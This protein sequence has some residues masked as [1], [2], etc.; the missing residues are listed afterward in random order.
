MTAARACCSCGPAGRGQP[1]RPVLPHRARTDLHS[2][3]KMAPDRSAG[4][5]SDPA[6]RTPA[7]RCAT[8]WTCRPRPSGAYSG[9]N[10]ART[11]EPYA[12]IEGV[13]RLRGVVMNIRF[14]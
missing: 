8:P 9:T 12:A 7:T 6:Q 4:H 14:G 5:R 1:D 2:Y 3:L 13:H 10:L 11:A